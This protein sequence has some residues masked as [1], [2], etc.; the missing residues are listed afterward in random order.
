[1]CGRYTLVTSPEEIADAFGLAE[2]LDLDPHY[3]ISPSQSIVAVRVGPDRQRELVRLRWGLIP[4]WADDPSIGTKTINA[5]SETA[6]SKPSFRRPFRTQRCLIVADGFYEW[7][8]SAGRKQP[9]YIRL[10]SGKPFGLAALW[11]RWDK[12]GEP[13][14]SCAILTTEANELMKPLHDR[15]P[16][17][18]HGEQFSRWLDPDL[19]DDKQLSELLRPCDADLMEAYPVGSL[20]NS[21]KHDTAACIVPVVS[22]TLFDDAES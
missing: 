15:M 9:Y 22:R 4:Y 21:P 10:K 18:L 13:I 6:A 17:I 16:V 1:M 8:Q 19:R 11:D 5:R 12:A 20:V 3:N 2:V 14:E 7:R